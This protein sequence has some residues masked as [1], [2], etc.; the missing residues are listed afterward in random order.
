MDSSGVGESSQAATVAGA[1]AAQ[2]EVPSIGTSVEYH[3]IAPR[4]LS[5]QETSWFQYSPLER[6]SDI[7]LLVLESGRKYGHINCRLLH[8]PLD[9]NPTYEALSYA[10]GDTSVEGPY[11]FLNGKPFHIGVNLQ[12]AL[13]SLC[14]ENIRAGVNAER[15]LWIDAICI[16]QNDIP[17]RNEQVQKMKSIY[18]SASKVVIWL[19]DYHEPLDDSL[20]F[21]PS[22]WDF[23][24]LERG[25][26]EEL[27]RTYDLIFKISGFHSERMKG[28]PN[29]DDSFLLA[30]KHTWANLR[31]LIMRP[32]FERLWVVQE[33]Y[34]ARKSEIVCGRLTISWQY[35]EQACEVLLWWG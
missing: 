13:L 32:W 19:G 8:V 9:Y 35:L 21:D 10:W 16:N 12:A 17:E 23:R 27:S 5:E 11:I 6:P 31:R 34:L 7:R 4:S 28:N 20:A 25:T 22:V 24:S 30:P 26:R 1:A 29:P 15:I 18:L 3:S 33:R 14:S 2:L